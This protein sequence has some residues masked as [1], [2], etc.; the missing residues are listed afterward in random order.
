M[1][2]FIN[3]PAPEKVTLGQALFY[4]EDFSAQIFN[5][6]ICTCGSERLL[7]LVTTF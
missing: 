3:F 2:A 7:I 1:T 5:D 6:G 4:N